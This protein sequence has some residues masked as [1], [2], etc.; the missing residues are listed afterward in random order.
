MASHQLTNQR[1]GVS[2][3]PIGTG[4]ADR[5]FAEMQTQNDG[6]EGCWQ[7]VGTIAVPVS[8]QLAR[9]A[10]GLRISSE[11][12]VRDP[13]KR[14]SDTKR[15]SADAAGRFAWQCK[16]THLGRDVM[17]RANSG[18]HGRVAAGLLRQ[19]KVADLHH[20]SVVDKGVFELDV[21][22]CHSKQVHVLNPPN[23]VAEDVPT[24]RVI[25]TAD[26]S[27]SARLVSERHK[28]HSDDWPIVPGHDD[29]LRP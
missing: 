1:H 14:L 6:N 12:V 4:M 15:R 7:R 24:Q 13:W 28:L 10:A 25:Q 17:H 18:L 22:I 27:E 2:K 3:W 8:H 16:T 21:S 26:V 11:G 5:I 20:A 29:C 19:A 9:G 23:E